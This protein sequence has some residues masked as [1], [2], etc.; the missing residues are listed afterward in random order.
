MTMS[1][2]CPDVSESSWRERPVTGNTGPR[3][4]SGNPSA[5]PEVL[6]APKG[7]ESE[8]SRGPRT[9]PTKALLSTLVRNGESH[10][11]E[12]LASLVLDAERTLGDLDRDALRRSRLRKVQTFPRLLSD[13]PE[14][15]P[16][17]PLTRGKSQLPISELFPP[18]PRKAFL[19]RKN[20]L[21]SFQAQP[22]C[23]LWPEQE[24]EHQLGGVPCAGR[25]ADRGP[26]APGS[27][28]QPETSHLSLG[29]AEAGPPACPAHPRD[30]SGEAQT[31]G[32]DE[33]IPEGARQLESAAAEQVGG[34][35]WPG[36]VCGRRVGG[37]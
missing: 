7:S 18:D 14:A 26:G 17:L 29:P 35:V 4:P 36:L 15:T 32:D 37:Q 20:G 16:C 19:D 30:A 34:Q 10:S 24:L 13:S 31:P 8:A 9:S 33:R 21:S 11:R 23:G 22:K 3:R 6:P 2:L 12:E 1:C 25:S 28:G 27:P 5:D